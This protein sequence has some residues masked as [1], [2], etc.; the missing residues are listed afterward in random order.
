MMSY[1]DGWAALHLEM[2]DRV[3]HTEYSLEM[4]FGLI[5]RLLGIRLK[6]GDPPERKRAAGVQLAETLN[7]DFMWNVLVHSQI[8]GDKLTDMGHAVYQEGGTDYNDKIFALYDDP[9]D[10]LKFDPFE[11]YGPRDRKTLVA[12]FDEH[13][14]NACKTYGDAVNMTGIYVTIMSGFI[15]IMGW[16]T[17]LT[18]CGKN[19]AGFGEAANRYAAW[20]QQYYDALAECKSPVVMVHDDIVW[21]SGAFIH[22]DWYRRYVFPNYK[23]Y[24][25]PLRE[26]GKLIMFT[27][28][29]DYTEFIDDIADC[30][31]D[32]FVMEPL[33]DMAY[34]AE[35]YGKTHSFIGNADTR[36]L[37]TGDRD[38]I[39]NEV[40]RCMD[41]GKKYPGFF[42]NVGN[43]IPP[44]TP[45]DA[46]MYYLEL[47][48]QM[49]RR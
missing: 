12:A 3:P 6:P 8:F 18:A 30:G 37:L 31:V 23:K 21:T 15:A 39:Y 40:K 42:M 13:Y 32:G 28:D 22:P 44:N 4:H 25:K 19:P 5:E 38:Q 29:G 11:L 27:S 34:I 48:E 1:A 14:D 45:T 33:T 24:F 43:H 9:E 2:P 26:A 16:D 35:K 7:Y 17:L 20:M 47:C 41:I 36:A 46:V 49:G 10:A